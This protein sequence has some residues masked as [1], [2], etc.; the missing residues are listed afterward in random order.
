VAGKSETK[1]SDNARFVIHS[2]HRIS[3]GTALCG[4]GHTYPGATVPFG[5]VQVSPDTGNIGWKY[6]PGYL[7]GDSSIIGFSH[8]HLS[9]TGWMDL[10]DLRFMPFTGNEQQEDYRSKFTHLDE[11]ASPGYYSVQLSDYNVKVE[12]TATPHSAYHRYTFATNTVHL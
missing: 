4:P 3:R 11:K 10:G 8:S 1:G 7:Y 5:L 9:G 6:C 2:L 12:L